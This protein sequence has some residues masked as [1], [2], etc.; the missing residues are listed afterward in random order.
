MKCAPAGMSGVTTMM[1]GSCSNENAFRTAFKAY[2]N[3]ERG[4]DV[5]PPE[6]RVGKLRIR[7]YSWKLEKNEN[8]KKMKIEKKIE[9]WKKKWKLKKKWEFLPYLNVKKSKFIKIIANLKIE[10]KN[11]NLEKFLKLSKL[12]TKIEI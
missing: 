11:R 3:R 6:A 10:N 1:C 9:N 7:A 4:T 12:K 8:W 5:V 2:M